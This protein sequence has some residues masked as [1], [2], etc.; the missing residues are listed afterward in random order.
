MDCGP[1]C[2]KMVCE[3]F[4]RNYDIDHL[5]NL[6]HLTKQGATMQGM[7][8]ASEM[9]GLR[10]LAVNIS[11]NQLKKSAP[12]PCILHWTQNHYVVLF[13]I[14]EQKN[15]TKYVIGDPAFELI[16]IEEEEFLDSWISNNNKGICLLFEKTGEFKESVSQEKK[17]L[18][19]FSSV[20][21]YLRPFRAKMAIVLGS[22]LAGTFLTLTIP[23]L[24]Q[25]MVDG[26]ILA[27]NYSVI[28]LVLLAQFVIFS[29]SIINEFFRTRILLHI[30]N[31]ITIDI[32]SD[33]LIKIFRLPIRFFDSKTVGD[34]SQRIADHGKV[35]GFLTGTSITIVFSLVNLVV[36]TV[37]LL[38]YKVSVFFIFLIFTIA[39]ILWI[40]LFLKK[41]K[42][43]DFLRF[44]KNAENQN[45]VYEL[46]SSMQEIKVH[47]IEQKK[48]W[49][50]EKSQKDLN[51]L[52]IKSLDLNQLQSAGSSLL[53]HFK[54]III[55]FVCAKSVIEG[56]MTLGIMMSVSFLIGQMRTPVEQILSFI[57]TAQDA[58][59]SFIR[60]QEIHQIK[61]EDDA[62][63]LNKPFEYFEATLRG[64]EAE[65]GILIKDLSFSYDKNGEEVL[66]N[67]NLLIPEKKTT[68]IVGTSGSGKT[69]L[70]KMLLKFYQPDSG[71]ISINGMD[72][73]AIPASTW[74]S[75]CGIFMQEG[76]IFNDSIA[77]NVAPGE[78]LPDIGKV[79]EALKAAN[80]YDY[81]V[82]LAL[83]HD[84][85]I[86]SEGLGLSVGQKQRILI[87]RAIYK[88]PRFIFFDE[89]TSS[90]D[91]NNEKAIMN[92]LRE[93]FKDKTVIT[94]AH[95]LS[96]VAHADNIIVM[97]QGEIIEQGTHAGLISKQ[98][99]YYHLIKN[100]LELGT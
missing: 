55:T 70:L 42:N 46:I 58:K 33:F 71:Q 51:L 37:V 83:K 62:D 4:G 96:T 64:N 100:Q 14:Q 49:K 1:T 47:N 30:N 25:N 94:V 53:L 22:L 27:K 7:S 5:R 44:Q 6:C 24:M 48:R 3:Y 75:N 15:K 56:E 18:T 90:L 29:A 89:A 65:G 91:A 36:Y 12:L 17:S 41:R 9:I 20:F 57:V 98:G 40:L 34:L 8:K 76:H 38:Y 68:A 97:E 60:L 10:S 35:Q 99:A 43:L 84:T 61:D 77:E 28:N 63:L 13:D 82:N 74:R 16:T 32:L 23:F 81:V 88:N 39:G 19:S 92:N 69:T 26:G 31:K 95:R 54:N 85:K 79:D 78:D 21:K 45:V 66:K 93:F 50:W 59:L 52:N 86:G 2:L 72:L 87:A 11:I 80:I 73:E 67:I